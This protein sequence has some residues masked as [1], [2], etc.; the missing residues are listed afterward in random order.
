MRKPTHHTHPFS[1]ATTYRIVHNVNSAKAQ[2]TPFTFASPGNRLA[3]SAR[4]LAA[5]AALPEPPVP[6]LH[7]GR[8]SASLG[9][10]AQLAR[11]VIDA[12]PARRQTRR[13]GVDRR[14]RTI[15]PLG[16]LDALR[17]E[18]ALTGHAESTAETR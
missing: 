3:A 16:P 6:V 1:Y 14:P 17:I 2:P 18:R 8:V 7:R 13:C 9:H 5:K 12:V 10:V 4:S 11:R 15:H